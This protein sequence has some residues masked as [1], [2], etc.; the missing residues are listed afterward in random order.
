MTEVLPPYLMQK[1]HSLVDAARDCSYDDDIAEVAGVLLI[2]D[3]LH[4][5]AKVCGVLI[6]VL[7]DMTAKL[8]EPLAHVGIE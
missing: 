3:L 2:A 1:S 5:F 4:S 7:F 6:A 8:L